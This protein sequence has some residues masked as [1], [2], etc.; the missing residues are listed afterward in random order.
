MSPCN[1]VV[2]C[3]YVMYMYVVNFQSLIL[4]I[5]KAIDEVR[6]QSFH[7]QKYN[8]GESFLFDKQ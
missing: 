5:Y 7:V 6:N 4:G 1:F 3:V 8:V 2:V